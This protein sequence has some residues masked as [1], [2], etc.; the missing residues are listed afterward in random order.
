MPASEIDYNYKELKL[1]RHVAAKGIQGGA[2]VGAAAA[3]PGVRLRSDAYP[4]R[5]AVGEWAAVGAGVGL[6]ATLLMG[7]R[8]L[9]KLDGDGVA[10]RVA[11][12]RDNSAQRQ[13]DALSAAGALAF[14]A[15]AAADAKEGAAGA[16]G[17][18][19]VGSAC[20][21]VAAGVVLHC[22]VQAARAACKRVQGDGDGK[23]VGGE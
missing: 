6:A 11:K 12:L 23:R 2:L 21:G 9:V 16:D 5:G 8:A 7:A 14:A 18:A 19:V 13:V 10:G 20:V 1:L 15:S 22:V 4:D 3:V 17:R